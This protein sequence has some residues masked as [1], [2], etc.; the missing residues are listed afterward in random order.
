MVDTIGLILGVVVT[1]ADVQD[2]EGAKLV[3][4]SIRCRFGRLRLV[5]ADAIYE[6]AAG[7]VAARRPARPIR[8]EVVKRTGPGFKVL[9]RR[10]VV[11]RSFAWL[12]RHCRL[13]K[14]HEGTIPSS[15]AFVKLARST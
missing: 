6:R 1:A 9:P 5:W 10:R 12:G 14:D 8:L 13:S 2:P 15:E 3:F 11:E 7:W 4:E